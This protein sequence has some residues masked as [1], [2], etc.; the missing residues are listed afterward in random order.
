MAAEYPYVG[1]DRH[2][3]RALLPITFK[4]DLACCENG[5][6]IG[7]TLRLFLSGSQERSLAHSASWNCNRDAPVLLSQ[8]PEHR[9]S[10]IS[11]RSKLELF[12]P[13]NAIRLVCE[14]LHQVVRNERVC[15]S[16]ILLFQGLRHIRSQLE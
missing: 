10:T 1:I 2:V 12:A 15:T 11:L 13:G 14:V 6:I 5:T 4:A 9:M 7:R 16:R 8:C 3:R